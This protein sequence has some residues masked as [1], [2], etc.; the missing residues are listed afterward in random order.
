[1]NLDIKDLAGVGQPI[2]KAIEEISK[3]IGG[4]YRPVGIVL[5]GLAT[6]KKA[7]MLAKA[8]TEASALRA[9]ADLQIRLQ[10]VEQLALQNPELAYRAKQRLLLREIEG[11]ENL[12]KI[13]SIALK[14]L[15]E[16]VSDAPISDGWRRKFFSEAE[17]ICDDDL[18]TVWGKLL[19]GEITSPGSVSVRTIDTLRL[20]SQG[21]AA[22]F[23]ILSRYASNQGIV[24]LPGDDVNTALDSHGLNFSRILSLIDAGM[25]NAQA[26]L[27][28]TLTRTEKL[29]P[30]EMCRAVLE[31]GDSFVQIA[32]LQNCNLPALKLTQSGIEIRKLTNPTVDQSYLTA[33]STFLETKS[34]VLRIAKSHINSGGS[35]T[36]AFD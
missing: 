14:A 8:E 32:S 21:D 34:V 25:V 24:L 5:D 29:P 22:T 33:L 13:A 15:P 30:H 17:N 9:N 7:I 28:W 23:A 27:H 3:G 18:Q 1:V 6:G 12:E 2:T 10:R 4:L 35:V 16:M 36:L 31:Y 11:Q 19:A 26:I 20:L